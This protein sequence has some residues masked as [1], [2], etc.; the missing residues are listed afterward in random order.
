MNSKYSLLSATIIS[1]LSY[2]SFA[3]DTSIETIE[4]TGDFKRESIQTLSTSAIVMGDDIITARGATHLEQ[5]LNSA[6]NTNF[7]AGASR[8][9]F[10]QIR[11]I[12]LRS[13]FVDPIHPSV[14]MLVDNIDYSGLG[15]SA[16]LF[17]TEHVAIYRGPQ[18][19]RF[20]ADAMAGMID[21]HTQAATKES[22][23]NIKLGIGNYQS[24]DA[25]IAMGG[26]VTESTAVRGSYYLQQSDGYTDNVYLNKATQKLDEQV[27]RVKLHTQWSNSL[28]TEFVAHHINIDNGYDAFTLYNN[29]QS[30]ADEPGQDNQQSNAFAVKTLYTGAKLF[31]LSI[32]V[33]RL[34]GDTLYSYDEDWTCN[35]ASRA[36]V[37]AAGLH[38][39]GYS[40]TDSYQ[41]E[42]DRGTLEL[43]FSDKQQNWV[44]GI[45]AKRKQ[46][47]LTRAYTWQSQ[48]FN[49]HYDVSH[50]ALFGQKVTHI[51]DK[52]DLITGLRAERYDTDYFD[53]NT[54]TGNNDDWMWGTK[55]ALEHY[56]VPRTMIY[57][58]LSRGYKIGGINGEALARAKDEQLNVQPAQYN[59]APEYLW[60]AEF[61][62]KG[63]SE[64]KR[65]T[66]RV[67]AFYMH[68]EDMQ[69][70]RSLEVD[71]KFLEFI[72]N[73][74]KGRNYG[75][76]VEGQ[77]HYTDRLNFTYSVGYLDTK[78]KGDFINLNLDGRE[79]AQ[80]PKYQYSIAANY[81][82]TEQLVAA[83]SLDG[84]DDYYHSISHDAKANSSNLIN[85]SLSYYAQQWSLTAWGRNLA[86]KDVAARGFRF[87]NNPLNGY[88]TET[89]V[90]YAEPRLVGL[91][92]KYEI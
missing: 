11:G 86:D 17:D 23:L 50:L 41:R 69:V 33:S 2:N 54:I 16:L 39:D 89:Y 87:P 4:V 28:S 81:F 20:G 19:T 67:S 91:T 30:S 13:Q 80:A 10:V 92:F 37:C 56:V 84:K 32:L 62:V 36:D 72:D 51:S 63:S 6:A 8:G 12:G 49:S 66:V 58:S 73:A 60:N 52:T 64:D 53:N 78:V 68:R 22:A 26:A 21:V 55:L 77:F 31:D 59:F 71:R 70:K 34:S 48:D 85:A 9:R 24:K 15:G 76:E 14:G 46:V 5:M 83:L 74:S 45:S 29:R 27:G 65:H 7:T 18:G 90:Q 88:T 25:G 40:S 82:I 1:L 61:G 75:I 44:G 3:N 42:H 57:T 79:Q 43:T 38:P 35:D 47:E